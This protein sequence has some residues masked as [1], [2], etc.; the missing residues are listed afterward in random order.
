MSKEEK[1]L[2]LFN[3]TMALKYGLINWFEFFQIIKGL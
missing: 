1:E 3:A 2:K